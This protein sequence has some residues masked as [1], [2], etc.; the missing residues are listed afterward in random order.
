MLTLG[1]ETFK[2]KLAATTR[3]KDLLS[4]TPAGVYL[5]GDDEAFLRALLSHH[6]DYEA[7]A[8]YGIKRMLVGKEAKYGSKCFFVEGNNGEKIDF[9]YKV[10]LTPPKHETRVVEAFR[11]AIEDQVL[12]AKLSR[13]SLA[14]TCEI[15]GKSIRLGTC[16]TDHIYPFYR[17]RDDFMES[18]GLTLSSVALT[19]QTGTPQLEKTLEQD[20]ISYH[21]AKATLQVIDR[22]EHKKKTKLERA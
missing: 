10:C 1:S 5:T 19:S 9:S 22:E 14:P 17:L 11:L 7:K 2:S 21:R 6:Y 8:C 18:K 13:L 12:E 15:S 16:D 4:K 3:A 20:W